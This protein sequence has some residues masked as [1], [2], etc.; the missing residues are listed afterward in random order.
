[1][2]DGLTTQ[3]ATPATVPASTVVATIETAA[4]GHVQRVQVGGAST[5]T[6][7]SVASSA[8]NVT[9]L[10]AN[11]DR[12]G[13]TLFNDSSSDVFVKFGATASSSSF[14]IEMGPDGY[15]EV[16]F[17]YRGQIDAIW[18]TANGNMR[19]GEFT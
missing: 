13:A 10:S 17:G 5:C 1:M 4:E 7:T 18:G 15:F 8:T 16:P 9:L 6:T 2:A 3:S 11:A 19:I 12:L 14:N